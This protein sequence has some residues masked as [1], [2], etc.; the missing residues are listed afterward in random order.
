MAYRHKSYA[1]KLFIRINRAILCRQEPCLHS[2]DSS[3][4]ELIFRGSYADKKFRL[5]KLVAKIRKSLTIPTRNF[6][7][8]LA[9]KYNARRG[10]TDHQVFHATVRHAYCERKRLKS[11]S[12]PARSSGLEPSPL[13][14]EAS[15]RET[16]PTRCWNKAKSMMQRWELRWVDTVHEF[17]RL[18]HNRIHHASSDQVSSSSHHKGPFSK[19]LLYNPQP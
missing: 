5:Y 11:E 18:I 13:R 7:L 12:A 10:V 19:V 15:L 9:L 1:D 17:R 16:T 8:L 14:G 6:Y 4:D 2:D 3:R